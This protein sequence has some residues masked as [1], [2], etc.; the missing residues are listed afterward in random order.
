[1]PVRSSVGFQL[2]VVLLVL[3]LWLSVIVPATLAG[4]VPESI[5]E[6]G[7]PTNVIYSL[8]LGV[9]VPAFA[10]SA[11]WLR[12]RRPWGYAFTAVLLVTVATL[13][14]AVLAMVVFMGRAGQPVPLAQIVVF[15]TLT[16]VAIALTIRCLASIDPDV[17]LTAG[18]PATA[19]AD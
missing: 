6:A 12:E 9:L 17:G 1:V 2:L 10:L 11:Y 16:L 19:A 15:G 13:G 14:G 3:F 5:L 18:G 8:D 7:L 4:S